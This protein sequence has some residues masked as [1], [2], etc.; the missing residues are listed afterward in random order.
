[1]A[2]AGEAAP[3]PHIVFIL[4]DD[5]GFNDIGYHNP[6]VRTPH[7]DRLA[8]QGVRLENYYVQPICTPTRSQLLT[9]RYQI[10]TG[11]QHSI[12]RARQPSCLPAG[13]PTLAEALREGAGYATHAVGK[14]HL[15]FWRRE[16]LPTSRGFDSFLGSLT[17]SAD[18]F[19]HTACAAGLLCG[20]DHSDGETPDYEAA[21]SYS[22]EVYTSAVLRL[23]EQH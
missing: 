12:I 5:Q 18:H 14:W 17:G 23:L 15:G 2:E 6:H 10:H 21:G 11:M 3:R 22:T 9:G 4:V 13:V 19:T 16:C 1:G 20:Y 8:A 7:L